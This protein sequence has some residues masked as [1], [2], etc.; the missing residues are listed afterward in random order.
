MCPGMKESERSA[1]NNGTF[2]CVFK[3]PDEK[4]GADKEDHKERSEYH[5]PNHEDH[6]RKDGKK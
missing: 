1:C 5:Q 4:K 2:C 3:V 6:W